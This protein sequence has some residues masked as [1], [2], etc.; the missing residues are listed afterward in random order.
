MANL[1]RTYEVL[2]EHFGT[3]QDF[4]YTQFGSYVC[5][6]IDMWAAK[7]QENAVEFAQMIC[8]MVEKVNDE[9]G[10]YEIG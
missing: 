6:L 10:A 4:D 2:N 1:M 9:L 7:N 8:S 5:M 3:L